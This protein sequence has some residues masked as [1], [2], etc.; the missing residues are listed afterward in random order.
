M[1][2]LGVAQRSARLSSCF[3]LFARTIF[4]QES[5]GIDTRV[6]PVVPLEANGV[7]PDGI[8]RGRPGRG[9]E[10]GQGAGSEFGRFAR[11]TAR[12]LPLL[13]AQRAGTRIA[14]EGEGVLRLVRVPPLDLHAR[15][16]G[17]VHFH[18]FRVKA[19]SRVGRV[20]NRN[21]HVFE[22]RT[23][24]EFRRASG[25]VQALTYF[26]GTKNSPMSG[27]SAPPGGTSSTP[28]A[29]KLSRNRL[30]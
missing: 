24:Q 12:L 17:D 29:R 20:R 3:A 4:A 6:V 7:L 30:S 21:S 14:K 9:L 27:A 11:P 13:V 19:E 26:C 22:Y 5:P 16:F 8:Y 18:R 1:A 23:Q 10:H 28:S 15:A 25:G 2:R